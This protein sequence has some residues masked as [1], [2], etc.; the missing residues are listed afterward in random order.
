MV[1][2]M[3]NRVYRGLLLPVVGFRLLKEA[4]HLATGNHDAAKICDD[5]NLS[6]INLAIAPSVMPAKK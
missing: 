6:S 1:F 5:L 2:V 3:D 4:V